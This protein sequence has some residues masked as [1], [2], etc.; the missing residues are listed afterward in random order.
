VTPETF[1]KMMTWMDGNWP[2]KLNN[3]DPELVRTTWLQTLE[4]YTD[5]HVRRGFALLL[6]S[7][8]RDQQWPPS[9]PEIAKFAR[10]AQEDAKQEAK[11]RAYRVPATGLQNG[12]SATANVTL[13][14]E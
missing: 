5:D 8:D 3:W 10:Q 11:T 7:P 9:A 2:G 4:P 6:A 12:D 13:R 1:V 14:S